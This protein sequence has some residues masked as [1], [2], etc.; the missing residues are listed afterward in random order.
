MTRPRHGKNLFDILLN[1]PNN[2]VGTKV[3]RKKWLKYGNCWFEVTS[4]KPNIKVAVVLGAVLAGC[5][6]S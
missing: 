5:L 6:L 1:L 2:G 4:F 3:A